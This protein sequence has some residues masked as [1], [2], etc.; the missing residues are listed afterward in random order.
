MKLKSFEIKSYR[1]CI[2]TKVPLQDQ[3]TGLIGIN[4]AGKSNILNALTLL[5]KLCRARSLTRDMES[6]SRSA[7]RIAA[8][9]EHQNKIILMKGNVIYETDERN[10]DEVYSSELKFNLR[11][12][13]DYAD[14]FS[15][16]IQL[17]RHRAL[18]ASVTEAEHETRSAN[19]FRYFLFKDELEFE[20]I[21][22]SRKIRRLLSNIAAFFDGINYYSASQFSDPS[23]CPVS[24]ELEEGR[25]V[26]RY[27]PGPGHDQF[28]LDLY[29]SVKADDTQYKRYLNTVGN[30][31]IGLVDN[32]E[33]HEMEMPSSYYEVTA[34]GRTRK[35]ERNRLL[36][37]P[38]FTISNT[39]LSPNQLSEGTFK[40]LALV[41]YILTDDSKLL[42]IE[43]PEVCVH[44]GLLSSIISL[45]E[46][47]SKK[48]QIIMSTHSDFVLDHLDPENLVLVKWV[49]T[50]GTIAT[51]LNKH[52]SK[53]DYQALRVYLKESGNL[54]EYWKEG[55]FDNG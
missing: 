42:L 29:K 30:D 55:G 54:G 45:I 53:N 14:W 41:F 28:M 52:M 23:R 48:K 40:T 1:S 12:F 21:R 44:H 6:S 46:T 33:F 32:I 35:I 38:T 43:E 9:I 31:G 51:P 20:I 3:L 27:R 4:G 11:E 15:I 37:V 22:R 39:Q 34:G 2:K 50:R 36:V 26:R 24:I 13:G 7:C 8:E 16:P 47:Q 5:R 10:Y 17:F 25:P 49:P 19:M 18:F